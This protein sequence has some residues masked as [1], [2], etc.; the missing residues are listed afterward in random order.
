MSQAK[1]FQ[2]I[3][4]NNPYLSKESRM[5]LLKVRENTKQIDIDNKNWHRLI[6]YIFSPRNDYKTTTCK[7][8]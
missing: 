5:Y 4:Q 7:I 8:L 3:V 2:L 1:I 6:V